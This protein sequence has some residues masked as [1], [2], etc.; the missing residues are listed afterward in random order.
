MTKGKLGAPCDLVIFFK[1]F[2][3]YDVKRKFALSYKIS[4]DHIF[5]SDCCEGSD[6][7]IDEVWRGKRTS[8][9]FK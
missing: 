2:L 7:V 8:S 3:G 9:N 1:F 4:R 6:E 5:A